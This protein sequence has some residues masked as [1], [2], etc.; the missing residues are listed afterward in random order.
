[1]LPL[2]ASAQ[3]V[4]NRLFRNCLGPI[5]ADLVELEDSA[6]RGFLQLHKIP[7]EDAH[8]VYDLGRADLRSEIRAYMF[9]K[10][11]LAIS[12][13]REARRPEQQ[14]L[15]DWFLALVQQNEIAQYTFAYNEFLNWKTNPCL[16]EL[17]PDIASQYKLSYSGAPWCFGSPSD[18]FGGPPI[19]AEGYFTAFG[20]KQSYGAPALVHPNF[21]AV[22]ANLG[23]DEGRLLRLVTIGVGAIVSAG[24]IAALAYATAMVVIG[25]IGALNSVVIISAP[26]TLGIIG[27]SLGPGAILLIFAFIGIAG[28][29]QA[30]TNEQTLN[31][32][33]NLSAKVEQVTNTPPDIHQFTAD[34]VGRLK[35][36]MTLAAQT[37]PDLPSS[38]ALPEHSA[39]DLN[40]SIQASGAPSATVTD[41]L[42]WQ[43]WS[44]NT[45]S[46]QTAGGWLVQTCS[47]ESCRQSDTISPKFQHV[48]WA[49]G[50]WTAQ[51]V[52]DKFR[53][54]RDN[55]DDTQSGVCYSTTTDLSACQIYLMPR[56]PLKD[57]NGDL[58][59]AALSV[60]TPPVFTGSASLPFTPS[61]SST[62]MIPVSGNPEATI[63]FVGSTPALPA[64]FT[65]NGV[66]LTP[67]ACATGAFPLKFS[68]NAASPEKTYQLTLAA[69]NGTTPT[70]VSKTIEID[71]SPHLMITSEGH[72]TGTAASPVSFTVT[73]TGF[74]APKLTVD[75]R[76]LELMPGITFTDHGN[77]TATFSGITPFP[78]QDAFCIPGCGITAMSSQGTVSQSFTVNIVSAPAPVLGPPSSATFVAGVPNSVVLTSY[79]AST[80]V[81]WLFDLF[82]EAPPWLSLTDNGDG[83]ATLAGTP[84]ANTSGPVDAFLGPT[85]A[86][87]IGVLRR[88][89]LDVVNTPQF[90]SAT[91]A[92]FTVGTESS[93]VAST[94]IG[95]FSLT[96]TLPNGL[97]FHPAGTPQCQVDVNGACIAGTP[98]LGTGG[99]QTI[100]VTADAGALGTATQTLTVRIYEAP[101]IG[102]PDTATF[103]TGTT[104]SFA[105][106]ATGYPSFSA[107]PVSNPTPPA[108]PDDG[109]GMYFTVTGLPPNFQASNLTSQGF[110]TGTLLIEGTPSLSDIGHYYVQIT[111]QNG[112]GEI[113]QQTLK[114][115]ITDTPPTTV[116]PTSTVT[117][118]TVGATSTT[119][120]ACT[121][122][123]CLIDAAKASA[124]CT[125]Q[126]IPT[127]V[128]RKLDR[129][130]DLVEQGTTNGFKKSLLR[131]TKKSLKAAKRGATKATKG[132]HPKLSAECGAALSDA[133]DRVL[134]GL[135]T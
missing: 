65:M 36:L 102:S 33:A 123:P 49:G 76:L 28:G 104:G 71:V 69:S 23:N 60:L 93:F 108:G 53:G 66:P 121:S 97:A 19:P 88:F 99:E 112:V 72:I 107:A 110:A 24:G 116:G 48:D 54:I 111:A 7:L 80:P 32:L 120:P 15:Y 106:V 95:T 63:C 122:A 103:I 59:T 101:K 114:L 87:T 132:K 126:T 57:A 68:G 12:T 125:G 25:S 8:I 5:C 133:A 40:F 10:M 1:M 127:R 21:G 78:V 46:A 91:T 34:K 17:D 115:V 118:T 26:F 119:L 100:I 86:G 22:V 2:E 11:V 3:I 50:Q 134:A 75:P 73:T 79:G 16:F 70:P 109:T 128:L 20:F 41:T 64:D 39:D 77:G 117:T 30:F 85:A 124:A 82:H 29:F 13:V 131:K 4:N 42:T 43:D 6:V 74:P 56:I 61:V 37:M 51:R 130:A 47:G 58:V 129:A 135:Q 44:G 67:S 90:I 14:R 27:A 96:G 83:T 35:L 18:L 38:A 98:A 94:N 52:G 113:A 9:N 105:V 45:W 55:P 62:Q 89:P 31:N 84:P 81:S 92:T